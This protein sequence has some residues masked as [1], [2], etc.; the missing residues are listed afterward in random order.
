MAA[1]DNRSISVPQTGMNRDLHPSSLTEQH[2]TFAMNANIESEDGNVGM[3]SNE[4]SNMKC[5][6]F[7]GFKVIGYKNDLTSGNIYFFITNPDTRVS[8]ITY[9]KPV[10][11]VS[12]FSDSELE[13]F[14]DGNSELCSGM[15]TLIEDNEE[16]PCLNFSIYHPVKTIEIK[17]EK[18]GK[19]IYWTDDYNPPRY[20]IVEKALEPDGDGDIW[21]HYHGY[22]LCKDD[23]NR[24][25]F[26][27]EN[28]CFLACEKLRVF[29]LLKQPCVNTVQIEYGG[30]LRAGV[31]QFAVALCD[32]F[33]NEKTSYVSLTNPVMVFDRQYIRIKDGKWGE[34]TNLG[35]RVEVSNLDMQVN[36]YKLAVI[37]NTVGYNGE[38]QPVVDY[39][40][41]GIHPITETTVLYYSDLNNQRTTFGHISLKK[42]VYNTSRGIVSVGNRLVQY[43]LT[44]E[45]EWNLQPVVSLMGHFLKWHC[46]VANEDLYKDG[47]ACSL[48]AG[49]MRNEVY[50]FSISFKTSSGYKTPAFI[51]IPPP[52]KEARVEVDKDDIAYRSISQ[53][54]PDCSGNER[55]YA[56]QYRN[57][58]SNIE[59]LII[60]GVVAPVKKE[61]ENP[62]VIGKTSIKENNFY[63]LADT[64]DSKFQHTTG[65]VSVVIKSSNTIGSVIQYFADH[66]S[67]LT[68][69]SP[70]IN[71]SGVSDRGAAILCDII[72]DYTSKAN[73]E[74]KDDLLSKIDGILTP[75]PSELGESCNT[76]KRQT[77][78]ITCP[79][80]SIEAF[81]EDYIYKDLSEMTHVS[82]DYLYSAGGQSDSKYSLLFDY[83]ISDEIERFIEMQYLDD[84]A[85]RFSGDDDRHLMSKYQPYFSYGNI[86][87][88]I[89]EVVTVYDILPCTCGCDQ[90][91]ICENPSVNTVDYNAFQNSPMFIASHIEMHDAWNTDC[92]SCYP[93][94]IGSALVENCYGKQQGHRASRSTETIV[95]HAYNNKLF[96]Q[97]IINKWWDNADADKSVKNK[98][99]NDYSL[100][101]LD[102]G[103]GAEFPNASEA[104]TCRKDDP[105]LWNWIK[106]TNADDKIDIGMP[107]DWDGQPSFRSYYLAYRF[108]R[109]VNINAR[110]IR[111]DRPSEWDEPDYLERNKKLYLEG[112]G[113]KDG[114]GDAFSPDVIRIAFWA[115]IDSKKAKRLPY[116]P[117][118]SF[119]N[120]GILRRGANNQYYIV[121]IDRPGFAEVNDDFFKRIGQNYFYVTIDSPIIFNTWFFSTRQIPFMKWTDDGGED[122]DKKPSRAMIGGTF[123]LGKTIYPYIF[124]I[125]EKEVSQINVF[126]K[127]LQLK[128]TVVFASQC[129]TCGDKPLNCAPRPYKQ[130]DFAYWESSEIY[131]ANFELYDSSR[132]KFGTDHDYS[133]DMKTANE[134]IMSKMKEWYGDM[135]KDKDGFGHFYGTTIGDGESAFKTSTS[136]CQQN[137]RHYK[138]PDNHVMPFMNSDSRGYDVQSEIYPIGVLINEDI[139]QVFLDYAVDSG[140]ITKEQR[141]TVVGYEIY[142]GDRKLNRSVLATGIAFD[143]FKW[144]GED[145]NINLY[146][147]YPYN[148]LSDDYY[149]YKT[150]KRD[151]VINHP[152]YKEGNVWYTFHSPDFY[153]NKPEMPTEMAIEGFQQGSSVGIFP[154]LKEHPKWTILGSK[155]YKMANTL[156][157]IESAA[158]IAAQIADALQV[159][160]QSA[161][162][163]LVGNLSVAMLFSSMI[164]TISEIL[165]KAPILHG[166]YRY[167]WLNI[168]VNNGPRRNHAYYYASVGFYNSM[169]SFLD[170]DQYNRNR[171]RGLS[172]VKDMKSGLYPVSDSSALSNIV[173]KHTIEDYE[174]N[175]EGGLLFLNNISRES[176]LFLS[177]GNPGKSTKLETGVTITDYEY[178]VNYPTHVRNFDDSRVIDLVTRRNDP[179]S[180]EK[181]VIHR[182]LSSLNVPYMK[183]MRYV[184]DQY[185]GIE[186]IKW[187]SAGYCGFFK[188]GLNPI[189]GGDIY[190][191]RFSMKRKF[192]FFTNNAFHIGDMIP[193]PYLDYRNIGFPRY[194]VDYDTGDDMLE[195]V[196]NNRFNSWTS[197]MKGSYSFFPNRK[198]TYNLNGF[199]NDD[200][201]VKGRFYTWMYG[202]PQFLVESELNCNFRLE[203]VTPD[204]WFYPSVGDYEW[205]TQ[206]KNV[207]IEKDNDYKISPIYSARNTLIPNTLPA[208]Y[209]R[210]FYDCAYQR[211]NGAIWSREDVSENSQT[212]PWLTYKPMD[213]HE[214]PT[215]NGKLIHMK[216]I[217]S[218]QVLARFEDQVSLH[219]AIDVIKERTAPGQAE[220]GTGGL[221]A[222]RPLE[223]NTTD[224][225]YSGTQSTEMVSSEFGHF[226]VDVKRGQ[227]F[228]TDP[229]GRNLKELSTGIRHWLKRHL[230]FKILRYN[231]TNVNTG[232]PMTYEDVDNKFIGLGLSLGWDNRYKRVFITKKDYIPVQDAAYYKYDGGR[233]FYGDSEVSLKDG[234][235]FKDVSFT[236]GYSCLKQEWISYYSFCPDY[237]I[238]QQ[239][240]F[241]SGLNF[242]SNAGEEGLWSHLLTNKAF[243]TFYG[244]TY[245]F[246]LEV[247]VKEKYNGSILASVEYELDARKYVDDVNYTLDRKVGLD[248]IVIYNDTNNSG[249]I[250]LVPADKNNMLQRVLY[251]RTT[252]GYTE[253][254]DTE[255]YR[256]HKLND[257]FNRVDDDRS[258]TPIWVKDDNDIMKEVDPSVLNFRKRW[259]DRIRGSWMLMRIRKVIRDRKIIFQWLISE[260][261]LK[262]R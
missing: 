204:E 145:G 1:E 38:T 90:D 139:I 108:R 91:R 71:E 140:L 168:F 180:G 101:Y 170:E 30:S 262:N 66:I 50:P 120:T 226:W 146:S 148:D 20:V 68:C 53:Y 42:P 26:M 181:D 138:F 251:P 104:T 165:S 45:K 238:E 117:D 159:R 219:N 64:S 210:K 239:G 157:G 121:N 252:N 126:A 227:V 119:S 98:V 215:K 183:A 258:E 135:V 244:S 6:D 11:D 191:S 19:C 112:L 17:T 149:N 48:Y 151:A 72:S 116:G 128:S 222:S 129:E 254:L 223:Y 160:A 247:P 123:G 62:A 245:P 57:T 9:F 94:D 174:T 76:P 89:S 150:H 178:L 106:Y 81:K 124:G 80:Q 95:N 161:Y 54:T 114:T 236:I 214:F 229:N 199:M 63:R 162:V 93:S 83:N 82:T 186:H 164:L 216:C 156:A 173:T 243:Q 102:L 233:F 206:E 195:L 41:E 141:E 31:Y 193:F 248:D 192:P 43:G 158:T 100:S 228:M 34:R 202:I 196:D 86:M 130:G 107:S 205:W 175:P 40:I 137:I 75:D 60:D 8:K 99:D 96:P 28:G 113:K 253:V 256:R 230:P 127:D 197:S 110:F 88:A 46:G 51:L 77:S 212:D 105:Y 134:I 49:Y 225:G 55:K 23:Y 27:K 249:D 246:I 208:T 18:C 142:R 136:F 22:K 87:K 261:K 176:C 189:Y 259:L 44:A 37:Q 144:I 118:F 73:P 241:Q 131:P 250:H 111:I 32:E 163:G 213:Y 67:E 167:D 97:A 56:W 177:F 35:I 190:I 234:S 231:I 132:V 152:F 5:M 207:S 125:R 188:G 12:T 217:E 109:Y 153:F 39:F 14:V 172:M 33:G 179:M 25:E 171:V 211:P 260:D 92:M 69:N 224:L 21:Y 70:F 47:N 200:K 16:D 103:S 29:P 59:D 4:H 15:Q 154:E 185:G 65:G 85:G 24:D 182:Y 203:G 155:A 257:F 201:Y 242:S 74:P 2:Y 58:A 220:M 78:V 143:M 232:E 166:K 52:Y 133:G 221:F 235:Y 13:S 240:F 184:P 3:R 61:C 169:T 237:Y 115:E 218:N 209:E 147:N 255:V 36:Y 79:V 198:S 84:E 10:E 7:A 122:D 187:V 194:F